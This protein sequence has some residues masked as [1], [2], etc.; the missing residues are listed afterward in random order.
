MNLNVLLPTLTSVLALVFSLVGYLVCL[1][2]GV[3]L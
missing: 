3:L 2:S 1:T